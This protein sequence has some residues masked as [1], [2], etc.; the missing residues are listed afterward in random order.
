MRYVKLPE[1]YPVKGIN[2][3]VVTDTGKKGVARYWSDIGKWLTADKRLDI[4]DTVV[5]WRYANAEVVYPR[6]HYEI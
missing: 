2:V 5:K 1:S 4:T 3:H 6:K